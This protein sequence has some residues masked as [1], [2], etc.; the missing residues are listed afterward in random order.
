L[1]DPLVLPLGDLQQGQGRPGLGSDQGQ[2]RGAL[3]APAQ[4]PQRDPADQ[5]ATG[6]QRGVAPDYAIADGLQR[7]LALFEQ[8]A[9][10]GV[11]EPGR[12]I[13]M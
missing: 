13:G 5:R 7:Q 6:T 3:G 9:L 8:G 12:G 10:M 1:G 4:I 2:Q 11:G